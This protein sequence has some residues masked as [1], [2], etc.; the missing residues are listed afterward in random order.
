[1]RTISGSEEK[2]AAV[3]DFLLSADTDLLV[4]L[5]HDEVEDMA[6]ADEAVRDLVDPDF[7]CVLCFG[8]EPPIFVVPRSGISARTKTVLVMDTLPNGW[9]DK[10]NVIEFLRNHSGE[11]IT[12]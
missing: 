2:K 1:M 7:N 5:S 9:D 4:I 8:A 10:P 11:A 6:A 3:A 12:T